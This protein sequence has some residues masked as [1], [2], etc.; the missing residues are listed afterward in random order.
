MPQTWM[1]RAG[2]GGQYFESFRDK[3]IVAIGWVE[4]GDV[5]KLQLRADFQRIVRQNYAGAKDQ[6]IVV[7]AGQ[8]FRFWREM[9]IGDR[10]VTYDPTAR[11]YL[12]G[13]ITG[14]CEFDGREEIDGLKNKRKVKWAREKPRDRLSIPSL[15]SL[16]A[17]LTLFSISEN[18][19]NELWSDAE[20]SVRDVDE[21]SLLEDT[22][23]VSLQNL[24]DADVN[25]L[26]AEAIK[27][28]IAELDWDEMQELVAGLLRAMG[29]KT[30]VSPAGSDRGK[31]IVAS[32]DG[33]GL[34]EPKII[35]EVKHRT[36]ERM[37]SQEIRSFLG[38]RHPKDRC[39]YVSTGGF[40]KDAHYEADRA[41]IPITLIDFSRLV[42]QVL[43]YYPKFDEETRQLLPLARFYWPIRK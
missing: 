4:A 16:G 27:D 1:V 15:N 30:V 43:E 26:S 20:T 24:G 38:G 42:E 3:E 2:R 5:S 10:V 19:S 23:S 32:P 25:A 34:V 31:D 14:D 35:V 36:N 28:K 17:I 29:F 13:Q 21:I 37:G 9:K 11:S 7:A 39:L 40:T 18:V 6:W 22:P 33:L 12:C 8:I 41:Q